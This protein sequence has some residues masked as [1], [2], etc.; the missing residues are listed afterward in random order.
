MCYHLSI[1]MLSRWHRWYTTKD[2]PL[3]CYQLFSI[4]LHQISSTYTKYMCIYRNVMDE[5]LVAIDDS[6]RCRQFHETFQMWPMLDNPVAL[7]CRRHCCQSDDLHLNAEIVYCDFVWNSH[8]F[9]GIIFDKFTSGN[10]RFTVAIHAFNQN[11]TERRAT[12]ISR[13]FRC[14][15]RFIINLT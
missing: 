5:T 15:G 13:T 11:S 12:S 14:S 7:K 3:F 8:S 4:L 10:C 6:D 9:V 2:V 1:L